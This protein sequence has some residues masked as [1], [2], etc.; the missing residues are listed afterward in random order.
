MRVNCCFHRKIATVKGT[1]SREVHE[2][3]KVQVVH[4]LLFNYVALLDI[5]LLNSFRKT[6]VVLPSLSISYR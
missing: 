2:Y 3:V 1:C 6:R 4:F 5:L